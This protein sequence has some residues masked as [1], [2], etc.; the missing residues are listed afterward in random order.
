[1]GALGLRQ[2]LLTEH[3][4]SLETAALGTT[5]WIA[6]TNVTIARST[7]VAS[8]GVAS[9]RLTSTASGNTIPETS[10]GTNGVPVVVGAT[11]AARCEHYST[12]GSRD[13][14]IGIDWWKA[15]GV[16]I[17]SSAPATNSGGASAWNAVTHTAVA[18]ALAAF[19]SVYPVIVALG[20]SEISYVDKIG[21]YL[22]SNTA[23]RV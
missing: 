3:Q 20:A 2:N 15:D 13:I 6:D 16:Y 19:A 1:L 12:L 14:R 18:P 11:Y 9:L 23:W 22:G 17:S 21:F 5:G 8:L 7:T 4:A 10:V